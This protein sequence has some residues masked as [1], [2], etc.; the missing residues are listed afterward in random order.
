MEQNDVL[1]GGSSAKYYWLRIFN[2]ILIDSGI[3]ENTIAKKL[4]FSLQF[5]RSR[6][7]EMKSLGIIRC[8][9][10]VYILGKNVSMFSP[11]ECK[12]TNSDVLKMI[13]RCAE[14]VLCVDSEVIKRRT[15]KRESSSVRYLI[16]GVY[17][18]IKIPTKVGKKSNHLTM[19]EIIKIMDGAI[20]SHASMLHGIKVCKD[21]VETNKY[22]R[23]DYLEVKKM[24]IEMLT[25]M[26][27]S[28]DKMKF[29][30]VEATEDK[31][32]TFSKNGKFGVTKN[33][34]VVVPPV[35]DNEVDAMDEYD[36]YKLKLGL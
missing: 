1:P 8:R 17:N 21:L 3:T 7:A 23:K 25:A 11:D 30:L 16:F 19:R 32:L 35:H 2:L 29:N 9:Y 22:F 27:D 14:E 10:D 13:M 4:G 24:S 34:K 6:I 33:S 26:I 20:I 15:R 5:T 31:V 12:L 18:S 28:N 36:D